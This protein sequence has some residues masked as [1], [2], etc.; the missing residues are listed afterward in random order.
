MEHAKAICYNIQTQA[1]SIYMGTVCLLQTRL[2]II[3]NVHK[4]ILLQHVV[5]YAYGFFTN[6]T[7]FCTAHWYSLSVILL[8]NGT[9]GTFETAI[10]LRSSS[11]PPEN[12]IF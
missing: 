10:F 2:H 4:N 3:F 8:L 6:M 9:S 5:T 11:F 1:Y 7:D 12:K